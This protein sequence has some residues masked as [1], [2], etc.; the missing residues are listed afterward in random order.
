[1]KSKKRAPIPYDLG[2]EFAALSN[3]LK[4]LMNAS[5]NI[6]TNSEIS[7]WLIRLYTAA[8]KLTIAQKVCQNP[9]L[10]GETAVTAKLIVNEFVPNMLLIHKMAEDALAKM[11]SSDN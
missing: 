8:A 1:M 4:S 7:D 3:E 9:H 5:E 2:K 11:S 6:K 10:K